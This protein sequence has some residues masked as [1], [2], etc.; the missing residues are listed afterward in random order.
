MALLI[1][2]MNLRTDIRLPQSEII[3]KQNSNRSVSGDKPHQFGAD[4]QRFGN[5]LCLYH[6]EMMTSE[7]LHLCSRLA[8][9]I[10]KEDSITYSHLNSLKSYN[11]QDSLAD[12]E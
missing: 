7:T 1:E 9:L 11:K 8:Q 6:Q 4:I 5:L 2:R 3:K 12:V 10:A